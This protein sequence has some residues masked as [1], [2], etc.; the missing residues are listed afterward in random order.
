MQVS[1]LSILKAKLLEYGPFKSLLN[2]KTN[3]NEYK[4]LAHWHL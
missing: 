3:N 4:L 1:I 2:E